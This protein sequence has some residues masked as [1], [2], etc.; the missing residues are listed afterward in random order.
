MVKSRFSFGRF[1][2]VVLLRFNLWG[3]ASSK[4]D[5]EAG[6]QSVV[7]TRESGG[8]DSKA[9]LYSRKPFSSCD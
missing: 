7:V 3:G 4:L 9:L 6:I 1:I 2:V 8:V 5:F